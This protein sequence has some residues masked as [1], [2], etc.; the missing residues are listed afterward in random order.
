MSLYGSAGDRKYLNAAT[1]L[2]LKRAA[3]TAK[4]ETVLSRQAARC[5]STCSGRLR[6]LRAPH[7]RSHRRR[8]GSACATGHS[9]DAIFKSEL[10]EGHQTRWGLQPSTLSEC[11]KI[12]SR[13]G[14][15]STRVIAGAK[16]HRDV[17]VAIR[18]PQWRTG[19]SS[20][21]DRREM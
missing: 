15:P 8:S 6:E 9:F 19:L 10:A 12:D 2:H 13:W 14:I 21:R 3:R 1:A 11:R 7:L 16:L 20:P 4:S 18:S 17:L 5:C